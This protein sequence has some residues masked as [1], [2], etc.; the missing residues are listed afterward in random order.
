MG[1]SKRAIVIVAFTL[2]SCSTRALPGATPTPQVTA[3]RLYATTATIP[4]V[5]DLTT[6]YSRLNPS[7]TFE[8]ASGNYAAMMERLLSGETPFFTTSH[9]PPEDETTIVAFPVGQDGIAVIVHPDNTLDGLTIE[10]L[11]D[12]YQGWTGNWSDV[13]GIDLPIT[14][15]SREDGSGTRAEFESLVMGDRRTTQTAQVAPSS[16]AMMTAIA[17]EASSVGY[18]SMSYLDERV[19]PLP[20][21]GVL[22]TAENVVN[23]TYPLRSFLYIAGLREPDGSQP[24]DIHY[25]AFIG[26]VQSAEGQAVVARRYAPL[27]Q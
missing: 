27:P 6:T 1:R 7:I 9:L 21:N 14:V 13:G 17:R 10:A 20:I 25:R 8:I 3:L 26:W 2:V 16:A 15:F 5:N 18:V 12:I 24:D 11:R 23:N 22:P 4:L 19:R